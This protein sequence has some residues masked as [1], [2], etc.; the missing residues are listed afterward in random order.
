MDEAKIAAKYRFDPAI[1]HNSMMSASDKMPTIGPMMMPPGDRLLIQAATTPAASVL[2][3]AEYIC[4]CATNSI[5]LS[6]TIIKPVF[7]T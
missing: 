4:L 1:M 2:H 3:R 7:G 5:E 6:N